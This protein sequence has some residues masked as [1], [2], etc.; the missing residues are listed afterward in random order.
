[1]SLCK[2]Y[3]AS[4]SECALF[5]QE[6]GGGRGCF[7]YKT[8]SCVHDFGWIAGRK[9]IVTDVGTWEDV[10][11]L[12]CAGHYKIALWGTPS[13][14]TC[15]ELCA[16]EKKCTVFSLEQ[17][18]GRGCFLFSE[19]FGC[20][21]DFNWVGGRKR[22]V[23]ATDPRMLNFDVWPS[24][25]CNMH[26]KIAAWNTPSSDQCKELCALDP[27]C[28]IFAQEPFG[29]R[30]CFHFSNT[31]LCYKWPDWCVAPCARAA[32]SA[33]ARTA[34]IPRRA[35]ASFRIS[36]RSLISPLFLPPRLPSL[37]IKLF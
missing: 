3:C 19:K 34:R 8:F 35:S 9:R 26:Y 22:I 20:V 31:F 33:L 28:A 2:S 21:S 15:K 36:S 13:A 30:G 16:A 29:G 4:D 27:K 1:M 6:P 7:L 5:A 25:R 37:V 11:N 10:P 17:S 32:Q 14:Q 23:A 24:L 12:R 18:G